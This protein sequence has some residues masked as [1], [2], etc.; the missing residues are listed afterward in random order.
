MRSPSCSRFA[1][2]GLWLALAACLPALADTTEVEFD[3]DTL[4][5]RGLDPRLAEEF[6][7]GARFP[8]GMNRVKLMVNGQ[9]RGKANVRFTPEGEACLTGALARQG[10]LTWPGGETEVTPERCVTAGS[11][12]PQADVRALPGDYASVFSVFSLGCD[13]MHRRWRCCPSCGQLQYLRDGENCA[14]CLPGSIRWRR[15]V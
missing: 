3:T 11:L 8:A 7:R 6:R 13:G 2:S 5:A 10:Q 15:Y 1:L 14:G 9:D 12:W 4:Q